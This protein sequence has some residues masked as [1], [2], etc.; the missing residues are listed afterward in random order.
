MDGLYNL[1]NICSTEF[2]RLLTNNQTKCNVTS[3]T[4]AFNLLQLTTNAILKP[5]VR[6]ND[7]TSWDLWISVI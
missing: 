7:E 6:K 2:E 3:Y 4:L 1:F 5:K